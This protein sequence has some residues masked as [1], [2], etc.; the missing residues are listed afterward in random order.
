MNEDLDLQFRNHLC[1]H[2]A[3]F[4]EVIER[5]PRLACPTVQPPFE[6]LVR[7]V[8]GQ[9]L[10]V[11]AA[12]KV[13]QRVEWALGG[14]VSADIVT[15]T[16]FDT[17]RAAGL[18]RAKTRSLIELAKFAGP[19][20]LHLKQWLKAPWPQF[21]EV[22]LEVRGIGPWSVDMFAMFGMGHLDIFASGDLGLRMAMERHLDVPENQKPAV[23]D[24]R[25]L[26]WSPY[27]T[28]GSLHL[29]HSLKPDHERFQT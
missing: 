1:E 8:S 11:Q 28:L 16:S 24:Q 22:L 10:S 20:E 12:A 15:A 19:N 29:W 21:R 4:F 27:R 9:Q 13:Y 7:I 18:S 3:T 5:H 25:A 2:D 17:L 23:Y 14:V 6:S 26:A